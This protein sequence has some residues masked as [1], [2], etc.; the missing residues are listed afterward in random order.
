MNTLILYIFLHTSLLHP[1]RVEDF[2]MHKHLFTFSEFV[3]LQYGEQSKVKARMKWY[4]VEAKDALYFK[5]VNLENFDE[6]LF[7]VEEKKELNQG[8]VFLC[9]DNISIGIMK[10]RANNIAV[11]V[12]YL[13]GSESG[14]IFLR[15]NLTA[16]GN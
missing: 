16:T 3:S 8:I 10:E 14:L 7:T 1:L 13:D 2:Q 12:T 4:S 5:L 9:K 15:E 6:V 11:V